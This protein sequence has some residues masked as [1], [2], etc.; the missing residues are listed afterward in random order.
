MITLIIGVALIVFP[1]WSILI[2]LSTIVGGMA[3]AGRVRSSKWFWIESLVECAL[4][5]AGIVMLANR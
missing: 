1:T 4:I 3:N 5:V 2:G